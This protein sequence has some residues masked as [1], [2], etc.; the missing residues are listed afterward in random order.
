MGFEGATTPHRRCSDPE[1]FARLLDDSPRSAIEAVANAQR[2]NHLPPRRAYT[3]AILRPHSTAH[4]AHLVKL[5][6]LFGPPESCSLSLHAVSAQESGIQHR[7][8]L[9]TLLCLLCLCT[10]CQLGRV[11]LHRRAHL[12]IG[13]LRRLV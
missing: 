12:D 9:T 5:K 1:C 4:L 2:I 3:I 7:R 8:P 6:K 10:H 11:Q 13:F